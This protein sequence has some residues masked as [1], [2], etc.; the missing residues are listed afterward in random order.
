MALAS[1]IPKMDFSGMALRK[2]EAKPTVNPPVDPPRPPV[3]PPKPPVDPP[4][5]PVDPPKPPVGPPLDLFSKSAY[6]EIKL[7]F[8]GFSWQI[9]VELNPSHSQTEWLEAGDYLLPKSAKAAPGERLLGVRVALSHPFCQ[10]MQANA[11][12]QSTLVSLAVALAIAQVLAIAGGATNTSIMLEYLS[13][14]LALPT[15]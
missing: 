14:A 4:K 12:G 7:K 10:K 2:N 8:Y 11:S 1:A 3:D 5:P 15:L 13:E 9:H 6:R